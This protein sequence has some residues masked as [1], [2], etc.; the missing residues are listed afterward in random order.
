[1]A[2]GVS[3]AGL[4]WLWFWLLFFP[5][6]V[7]ISYPP[8]PPDQGKHKAP[9]VRRSGPSSCSVA[10]SV[11]VG[12][13]S[14]RSCRARLRASHVLGRAVQPSSHLMCLHAVRPARTARK[15]SV[16]QK[17]LV[18]AWTGGA[19]SAVVLGGLLAVAPQAAAADVCVGG[20]YRSRTGQPGPRGGEAARHGSHG[21]AG[22]GTAGGTA[23]G[24][25][26]ARSD[27]ASCSTPT[28]R[29]PCTVTCAKRSAWSCCR[30]SP[31]GS[32]PSRS[33][34]GSG[35]RGCGSWS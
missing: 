30:R 28:S 4:L 21:A 26:A 25:V 35:I 20:A 8:Q 2:Q 33:C 11:P 15:V 1:M 22:A 10:L 14:P 5:S 29:P 6:Q 16:H 9:T 32:R 7:R 23:A 18:A 34:G 31:N 19:L 13:R 24:A 12:P 27:G 17:S 3:R